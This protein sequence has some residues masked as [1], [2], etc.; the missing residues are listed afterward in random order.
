MVEFKWV[1]LST[2]TEET[3][4]S[5]IRSIL[6]GVFDILIVS[7]HRMILSVN[8]IIKFFTGY[9]SNLDLKLVIIIK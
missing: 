5:E 8:Y 7:M 1:S 6:S 9:E 3:I 4:V 2:R